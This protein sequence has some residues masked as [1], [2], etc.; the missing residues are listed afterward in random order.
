MV[1]AVVSHLDDHYDVSLRQI[2]CYCL[3]ILFERLRG[4]FGEAAISDLYPKLLKRLD[5]SSDVIRI[6]IS[7]TLEMFM[8]CGANHKCYSS[9]M[10]DYTLDQCFIHLDDINPVIQVRIVPIV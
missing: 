3:T 2:S 4:A 8:A 10:V 9:T 6:A 7:Y 5:D 1:P